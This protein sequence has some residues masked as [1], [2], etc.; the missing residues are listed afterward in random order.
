M[1]PRAATLLQ[2]IYFLHQ[3]KR[4]CSRT[5]ERLHRTREKRFLEMVRYAYANVPWYRHTFDHKG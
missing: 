2:L 1:I 3:E 4:F 5:R